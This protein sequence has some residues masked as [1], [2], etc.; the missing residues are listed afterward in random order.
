MEIY[1]ESEKEREMFYDKVLEK[2]TEL[3]DLLEE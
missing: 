1:F 3:N 2:F